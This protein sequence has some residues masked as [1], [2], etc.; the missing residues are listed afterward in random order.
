MNFRPLAYFL[1]VA[2]GLVTTAAS[3]QSS[4]RIETTIA[5]PASPASEQ[6]ESIPI[7]CEGDSLCLLLP[8]ESPNP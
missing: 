6:L 2:L 8:G 1:T 5:P 7:A 3:A 4:E